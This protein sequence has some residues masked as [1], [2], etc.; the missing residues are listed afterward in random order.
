VRFHVPAPEPRYHRRVFLGTVIAGSGGYWLF[1]R[2]SRELE[3]AASL[4]VLVSVAEFDGAGILT[5]VVQKLR[6]HRSD[7]EWRKRLAVD[8]FQMTRRADTELAFAGEYWNFHEDGL[9]RCVCCGSALFDSK[10]KYNSGTGW[11]SFTDPIAKEN[12][13]ESPDVSFGIRRTAVSCTLCE[14]HLGHVFD[15]GPPPGGLRYCVNSVALK[16]FPRNS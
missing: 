5:A 13:T 12:V 7:E 4:P 15:D 9:Y 3:R 6:I 14:A 2:Q 1:A 10:T 16:F 8:E 11:P